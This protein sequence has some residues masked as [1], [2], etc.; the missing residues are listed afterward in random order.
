[1]RVMIVE[2]DRAT[3]ERFSSAIAGDLR[4]T[5]ALAVG[6]GREAIAR[7]PAVRPDVL[8]VDLGLPD[9]HGTE[10]IRLAARAL[11]ECDIMVISMFGDERNV[12]ASIQA[13]ATGYVLKDCAE[14]DLVA[15]VAELRAGGAPMS[16]G[17]ARLVLRRMRAVHDADRQEASGLTA[18]EIEVLQLLARGYSYAEVAERLAISRHTVCSHVKNTYRKLAVHTA[19][20]A[21]AR[22]AELNLLGK[23]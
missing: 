4:M 14:A 11:P 15:Q 13:G 16:P 12:L 3:R 20:Q 5:L 19:A 10:V 22:A 18:R 1:M 9:M 23:R 8:L 21:V 7:L 2:D 17:I 6:T